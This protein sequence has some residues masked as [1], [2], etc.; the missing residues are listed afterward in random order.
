MKV[1]TQRR[2]ELKAYQARNP[3][4]HG[5]RLRSFRRGRGAR[6]LSNRFSMHLILRS[7]QA[8]GARA[9]TQPRNRAVVASILLRFALKHGVELLSVGNNT[10]HLHLHIKLRTLAGYKR[11]IRA[12]TS[13]I[14]YAICRYRRSFWDLRP[15]TRI[16]VGMREFFRMEDY[17]AI[18]DLEGKGFLRGTARWILAKER[19]APS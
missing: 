19:A 14:A 5:S 7:T 6:P 17:I 9:F 18:N 3:T 4:A 2:Q 16:V 8:T 11:F 12:I 13:A 15:F 10:N 1:A